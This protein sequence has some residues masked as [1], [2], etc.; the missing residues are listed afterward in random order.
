MLTTDYVPGAPNWL[1]LGSPDTDAAVAFYTAVFGW[2]FEPAGPDAGGYGFFQRDGKVV[3][4]VGPLTEKGAASAWTVY[5]HTPD[6]DSTRNAVEQ[7]GG[8]VRVPPTD[9]F[10]AGRMAAFTDPTGGEFGV[11]QPGENAGLQTVM[12]PNSL[13]WT[14]LHTTD[15]QAAKGFYRS[16]FS[17]QYEDMPMGDGMVYTVVSAAGGGKDDDTS[18][19]GIMALPKENVRAGSASEWHPYFGVEDCDATFAAATER[20][21]TTLMPPSNAPGVGRLA[22][23]KDPA[24]AVFALIKG[25]PSMT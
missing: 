25:D 21:A 2:T 19:G 23:L 20:G 7:G 13:C 3:A 1:D 22:L 6:A 24:G 14:E 10:T 8:K 17:W 9:V 12:E 11:W 5:F 4:A 18:Q 15:A 16:V